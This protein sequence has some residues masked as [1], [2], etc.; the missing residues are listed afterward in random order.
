MITIKETENFPAVTRSGRVSAELQMI[1]DCLTSSAKDNKTFVIEGVDAGNSYNSMQQR[2]RTQAKK[3]G[4][5]VKI[6][7]DRNTSELY[8]KASS[9]VDTATATKAKSKKTSENV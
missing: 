8:F 3:L 6:S 5:S 1:I 7:H 2:I 9:P 4:L